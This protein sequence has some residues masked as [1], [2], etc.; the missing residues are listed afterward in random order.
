MA[1]VT[2]YC[3]HYIFRVRA[4]NS[5]RWMSLSSKK[6]A[7]DKSL[8]RPMTIA[9]RRSVLFFIRKLNYDLIVGTD[10]AVAFSSAARSIATFPLRRL[11]ERPKRTAQTRITKT[12]AYTLCAAMQGSQ[13]SAVLPV[14]FAS[15]RQKL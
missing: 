6:I 15:F 12:F 7:S 13:R 9:H 11:S 3:R 2:H 4:H 5:Y 8:L 10:D 14:R 1:V